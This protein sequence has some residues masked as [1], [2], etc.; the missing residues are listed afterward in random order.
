MDRLA[1]GLM[2]LVLPPLTAEGVPW[3]DWGWQ[4]GMLASV[5]GGTM[6]IWIVVRKSDSGGRRNTAI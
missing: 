4:S 5:P 1:V 2:P 6:V 3:V